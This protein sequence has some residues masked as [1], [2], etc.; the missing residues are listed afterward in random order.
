M[1]SLESDDD[2]SIVSDEKST[3]AGGLLDVNSE[4]MLHMAEE[5][6]REKQCKR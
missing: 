4:R 6:D 1:G 3:S 5:F 2:G